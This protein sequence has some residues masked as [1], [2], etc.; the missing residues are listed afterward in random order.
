[1]MDAVMRRLAEYALILESLDRQVE[2]WNEDDLKKRRR[3]FDKM[4]NTLRDRS[5]VLLTT[6]TTK[7]GSTEE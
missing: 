7:E 6:L 4:E 3:V 1:M 5:R 2:L